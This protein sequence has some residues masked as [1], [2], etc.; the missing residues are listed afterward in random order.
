MSPALDARDRPEAL[1][2]R[3]ARPLLAALLLLILGANAVRLARAPVEGRGAGDTRFYVTGAER[4]LAGQDLYFAPPHPDGYRPTIG[5]TYPPP[6]AALCAWTLLLPYP[7]LRVV[8][9]LGMT[10]CA[11]GALLLALRHLAARGAP[12]AR[13]ALTV[14]L[15]LPLVLR[16]GQNDLAHGQTNWLLALLLG[17]AL[18]AAARGQDLSAG[19]ALGAALALKPTAWLLLPW[20][21]VVERRWRAVVAALG[22]LLVLVLVLP[23]L[24]YGPLG[25]LELLGSWLELMRGFA[26]L[27]ACAP[28]NHAFSA[29]LLRLA[30][31][32]RSP[33]GQSLLLARVLALA[34]VAGGFL[35]LAL[36]RPRAPE[37]A[38]AVLALGVLASPVTWK[39]HLVVLCLPA[40]SVT[41]ALADAPRVAPL[42]WVSWGAL[43]ALLVLPSR[44]LF[45]L[46]RL[47]A[48][49]S[50]TLGVALLGAWAA[51]AP[52]PATPAPA[53]PPPQRS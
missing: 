35:T 32:D 38:V 6:F 28:D 3:R 24:R 47:E 52:A 25:A 51:R 45:A 11:L 34:L 14:L 2:R 50:L 41:R 12:P 18:L 5:Y 22:A 23:A 31:A 4:F 21:L 9:L 20:W 15:A 46:E 17:A 30:G 44:G 7:A 48:A 37:A 33:S 53:D 8:W 26:R 40:L 27:E 49:G 36:L 13:P 10:A 16:F 39:A 1:L 19:L 29:A 43:T 42:A